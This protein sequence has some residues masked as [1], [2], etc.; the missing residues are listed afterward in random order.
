[1][2]WWI[3][4]I[5]LFGSLLFLMFQDCPVAFSFFWS[6]RGRLLPHGRHIRPHQLI[7][8]ILIP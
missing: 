8:S 5:L 4:L 2:D 1:M 7:V 3:I 6:L